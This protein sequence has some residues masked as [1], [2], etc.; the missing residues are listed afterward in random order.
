MNRVTQETIE[1]MKS[2]Q[3]G[4]EALHKG[5]TQPTDALTGLQMYDL[6]APSQKLYPVLTPLRNRIPRVGG[7]RAVQA[8]WKAI[9]GIN[10]K[11]QRAGVSEGQRGGVIEHETV[12]R[13]AAYRSFGLENNVT[14][15]ADY[16]ARGFEDVKALAVTQTLQATML[17]EE[18]MILGGNTGLKFGVTPTP[19]LVAAAGEGT[20]SSAGLSVICVALGLQAYWDV[21]GANNGAVGQYLNIADAEIPTEITRQNADGSTDTFGG[22]SAQKSAA[23]S[24]SAGAGKVVTAQVD[25][26]RGAVAYAWFWGAAGAEKLGAVTTTAKV[27]IAA[28]AQGRQTAASLPDKDHSTSSLEFDGLLTQIALPDSGAYYRDNKAS[29]LTSDGAGGVYEFEEA[30]VQ[31]FTKYR[32]S[33]DTIYCNARDLVALT[34]LIIGN[35]GAPLIKL[36]VDVNNISSIKAGTVVASYLNKVTGDELDIVV[37]PNLPA[38]TYMFYSSKLP[39]YVQGITNLVQIRTRQ[40]YYQIEWP[41]RTRRYEYGVYADEVL[42][43]F[44]M[45][46]FGVITNAA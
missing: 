26:V 33:P 42:Q 27:E 32:L 23:A 2:A 25:A 10:T 41:L 38:G 12:E 15:E 43:G 16:A 13:M 37:H 46:A 22:G 14:F 3:L 29:G 20:I 28:D 44:F 1:L 9:T 17:A 34:R 39:A 4:G 19:K 24:V 7:G 30:F 6:S 11:N 35:N 40:D 18:M 21:A 31:F 8:N 36:N 45:P 5:F